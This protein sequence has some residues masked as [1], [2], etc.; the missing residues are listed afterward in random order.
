MKK[1]ILQVIR[2][3]LLVLLALI[4]IVAI[5]VA[6]IA[7]KN[8]KAMKQCVT[9]TMNLLAKGHVVTEIPAGEYQ[10]MK[11]YGIM[12]FHVKQYDIQD[13][14]NLSVMTVNIGM[15]QMATLVFTPLE[16]DLP[17][18]SCDYMYILNNR[19][20]Y[21]ELYDLV[22]EKTDEYQ[23]WLEKYKAA[24]DAYS[25]LADTQASAAWYEHLLTVVT[26]KA[27][28]PADDERLQG[29]LLDTVQVYLNQADS[30]AK[31][32]PEQQDTKKALIKNYS[33]RLIDEG[34][35]STD[36]FKKAFGPDVTRKFFDQVFFGTS[37]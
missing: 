29:L 16:K 25:D 5:V 10:E 34:G 12:K 7:K 8:D 15:M 20:A 1:K 30:Y 35:I 28:K 22:E 4:V 2:N 37:R 24:R 9:E 27:G 26:Y 21:V 3:V 23:S 18:L 31:M 19:K 33:D 36:F 11:A 13:V 17:L 6:V 32:E 14:G